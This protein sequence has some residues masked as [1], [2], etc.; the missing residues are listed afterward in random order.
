MKKFLALAVTAAVIG[1]TWA[2]AT[3]VVVN[4]LEEALNPECDCDECHEENTAGEAPAQNEET[5]SVS[6]EN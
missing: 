3:K 5:T 4:E 6:D 1:I 2:I